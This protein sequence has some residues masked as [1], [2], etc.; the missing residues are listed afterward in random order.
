VFVPPV[1]R[2]DRKVGLGVRYDWQNVFTD[3]NNIAPRASIP[4]RS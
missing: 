4:A 3:V 1:G 2:F